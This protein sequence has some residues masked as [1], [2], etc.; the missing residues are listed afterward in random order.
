MDQIGWIRRL[1]R[2]D[3]KSE[4]EIARITGLSRN[5]VSKW[6]RGEVA[7]PPKYRRAPQARKLTPFVDELK[8]AL[9]ADARRPRSQRRTARALYAQIKAAGY[10]GGYSRVTDFVRAWR[11]GEG[12]AVSAQAFIP[13]SFELGEAFQFD[14]SEEGVVVGGIYYRAQVAHLKL[15]ASRA[16]WLVAYPSQGHEMLFDAHNRS[17]AAL[18]GVARRGIYDNMKTAVDKVKKGKGRIVNARFSALCAHYLYEPDFCNVASGW[19]KGVV[20][21]NVQDSRRRIW[22]EASQRRFGSFAELNAW[23]G[24]RCRSLWDEIRHPQYEQFSVAE[25]LAHERVQLMPVTVPFDGYVEKP[26]RVSSTCLVTVARNRYSVPCELAGQ[27]V[28]TRLYPDRVTVVAAD[29]VVAS[30]ARLSNRGE[31]CYDWQHYIPLLQ[32]KPGA[33]RNGAPFAQMPEALQQLRRALLRNPG[34]DR[35]MAQVLAR[36]PTSGLEAVLVAAELVLEGAPPSGRIGAEHVI[37]VLAR[38]NA[39]PLPETAATH[40]QVKTPPRA[41]TARYDRLRAPGQDNPEE[42]G[43]A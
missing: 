36:V 43:H 25:M 41:D 42:V 35:V 33:L 39:A 11:T 19:E 29:Q 37:N 26:A 23:L 15:C 31:T 16:F 4:R 10:A 7:Q 13:L 28:S 1:H 22:S 3:K 9:Q 8:Q 24:Q 17:F 38:L 21:K 20:E 34:G 30:H 40:L 14:W 12:Q 2:R 6:L 27:A 18:G 32:R 5:T